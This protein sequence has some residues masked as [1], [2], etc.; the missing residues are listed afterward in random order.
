MT[1]RTLGG[2]KRPHR[3]ALIAG[4]ITH[5]QKFDSSGTLKILRAISLQFG[6]L[7]KNASILTFFQ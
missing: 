2:V 3:T 7:V 4:K 1:K 5:V 6:F